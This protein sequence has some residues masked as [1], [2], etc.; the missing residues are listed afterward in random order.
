MV[1]I[2][3]HFLTGLNSPWSCHINAHISRHAQIPLLKRPK[4]AKDHTVVRELSKCVTHYTVVL[5]WGSQPGS[6]EVRRSKRAKERR[7]KFCL[8]FQTFLK[9]FSCQIL[10]IY[11]SPR[12]Q[13]HFKW[14]NLRRKNHPVHVHT[15][16]ITWD[17]GSQ[18]DTALVSEVISQTSWVANVTSNKFDVINCKEEKC[19]RVNVETTLKKMYCSFSSWVTFV[20]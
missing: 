13:K 1:K 9:L 2:P 18:V 5:V 8:I 16:A 15:E 4:K 6:L 3:L 17:G 12:F 20:H 11:I 19:S 14:N 7:K 10:D